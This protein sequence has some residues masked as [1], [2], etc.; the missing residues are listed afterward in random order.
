MLYDVPA[1]AKVNLF[2]HIVGRRA[3]GYH[4]LQS[5]FQFIDQ[6]DTLHFDRRA[7]G[8]ISRS[9]DVPGVA[10]QDDLTLRAARALQQA[11]GVSAGV[12]ITLI[13]RIPTGGGLGGGSSDAATTLIALNRLWGCGL[14]RQ[15]LM[16]IGLTLGADVPVFI[17]GQTAF[18]EGVGEKLTAVE[19]PARAF[20]VAQPHASVPT[21]EIFRAEDLTRDSNS[22]RIT[23]FLTHPSAAFGRND[24][25]SVASRLYPEIRTAIR[26]LERSVSAVL[27]TGDVQHAGEAEEGRQEVGA[28]SNVEASFVPVVRMSGSGACVFVQCRDMMQAVQIKQEVVRDIHATMQVGSESDAKGFRLVQA[29]PGLPEHPLLNW[30][31][32]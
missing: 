24:L 7:D 29:C 32:N 11:A 12:D 22:I 9:V 23:D 26:V 13:K 19:V 1:P 15:A 17:F 16:D 30:I 10:E 14:S 25:E 31:A 27:A 21:Q 4:L 6:A 8:R 20:V 5:V 3:D 18:A 28:G 2:L